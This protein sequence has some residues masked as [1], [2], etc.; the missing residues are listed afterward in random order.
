MLKIIGSVTSPFTRVVRV[1]CEE[2]ALPYAFDITAPFGKMTPGQSAMLTKHNPLMKVPVLVDGSA[3]IPDSRSILRHL[4]KQHGGGFGAGMEDTPEAESALTVIYGVMDAGIL[5]FMLGKSHPEIRADAG[6]MARLV[7][8]LREGLG[9]L[10]KQPQLGQAF[11]V[12]EALLICG[13][14]WFEK[15][16]IYPWREFAGLVKL[17]A[18]HAERPSLVKTRIPETA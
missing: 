7:E 15:R 18:A 12:H 2:L 13:L 17:H 10:E 5:R 8:R 16:G 14:E 9:W 6:Y 3:I 1:A 11:G 4:F